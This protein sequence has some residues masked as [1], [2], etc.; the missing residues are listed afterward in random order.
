MEEV[1]V[2]Y[3]LSADNANYI[4]ETVCFQILSECGNGEVE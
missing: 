3:V 1:C 4:E 2:E